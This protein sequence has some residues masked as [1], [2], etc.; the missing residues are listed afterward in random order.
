MAGARDARLAQ[1]RRVDRREVVLLGRP[2]VLV[3]E[4]ADRRVDDEERQD[5]ARCSA[6]RP[7]AVGSKRAL[8][9]LRPGWGTDACLHCVSSTPVT[10]SD[11]QRLTVNCAG[12]GVP[13]VTPAGRRR[14]ANWAV[15]GRWRI[16]TL[17]EHAGGRPVPKVVRGTW[18]WAGPTPGNATHPETVLAEVTARSAASHDPVVPHRSVRD[19]HWVV[20][21]NQQTKLGELAQWA[22]GTRSA[23]RRCRRR[24]CRRSAGT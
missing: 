5:G 11:C 9:Y 24:R 8:R 21:S 14:A 1:A 4:D 22:S 23:A 2:V 17:R 18:R 7:P 15:G 6:G 12:G 19:H 10:R 20:A 13:R 3:H 16:T